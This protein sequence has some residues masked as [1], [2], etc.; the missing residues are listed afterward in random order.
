MKILRLNHVNIKTNRLLEMVEFYEDVLGMK[1]GRRPDFPFPGAWI[2]VDKDPIIHL[3]GMA[4]ECASVE[5]KIEHF[6]LQASG[7]KK[8]LETLT[9][10]GVKY[11]LDPV[12][13]Y[14]IVQVNLADVDGN[15]IHIDFNSEELSLLD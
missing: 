4:D 13:G 5:P 1:S 15:H 11:T 2:Y 9:E 6:A 3:V 8:L 12:P 14:P 10:R 7:L